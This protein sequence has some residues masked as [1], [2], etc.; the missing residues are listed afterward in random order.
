MFTCILAGS[1]QAEN[2]VS[3]AD[4]ID[5]VFKMS[6]AEEL[7]MAFVKEG[8]VEEKGCVDKLRKADSQCRKKVSDLF[9]GDRIE[10]DG[11]DLLG[12]ILLCRVSL[13][14]GME[15]PAKAN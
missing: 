10:G 13:L 12:Q 6:S 14:K 8:Y 7:C 2:Q 5:T 11:N 9:P 4:Y 3:K 1:A 15:F